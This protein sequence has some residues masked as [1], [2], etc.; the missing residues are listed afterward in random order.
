MIFRPLSAPAGHPAPQPAIGGGESDAI[1]L[2]ARVDR[3]EFV[4]D[5]DLL[6]PGQGVTAIFGPSGCGKTTLLRSTA[7]LLR[8]A[9]G[10]IVVAGETWQDDAKG[11]WLPT[12]RRP[13]GMVFQDA[14]LFEHLSVQ[15]NLDF[16]LKRVPARARHV[17]LAQAIEL[18]GIGHLLARRPAQLSG[19]ER[20][21]AGIA[22]ALAT[23]PRLLLMDEP[24]AA[25]DAARK[26]EL[27]PY[28]ERLARELDIPLLYVTHSLDEVARLADCLVLL[29][30]GHVREQGPV[31]TLMARPD[32]A[33]AQGD[34]ASVVIDGTVTAAPEGDM[35]LHLRFPGGT[36]QCVPAA[37]KPARTAGQALRVRI[38]ARDVSLALTAARDSSILNILP[39]TVDA[40]S[41]D[42]SAQLLVG[43][44]VGGTRLLARITRKSAHLLGLKAGM[45]VFAQIKGVAVLD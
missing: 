30:D 16:G 24:L 18:L 7:G 39:A 43:L 38:L 29:D 45:P 20:Q 11:L 26:A 10:R 35:L 22:R 3:G 19:G 37:H 33:R 44:D 27:L 4:L 25:L 42:G 34:A 32:L 36:L 40:L 6:L 13:L 1:A 31:G 14:G 28:F 9:P 21:R 17:S 23:S 5:V 15:A 12:H 2:R 41:D 8:P